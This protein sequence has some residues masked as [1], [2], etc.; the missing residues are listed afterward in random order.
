MLL[1]TIQTRVFALATAAALA[2]AP[3]ASGQTFLID[4]GPS[5]NPTASP[6][7]NGNQWNSFAPG[8][9]FRL[10]DTNGATSAGAT[11]VGIGFGA[12]TPV[13]QGPAMGEGL[14]NPNPA[15]LGDLAIQTAT[16][17]FVF[18]SDDGVGQPEN[19]RFEFSNLDQSLVYTIRVFASRVAGDTRETEY[20]ATGGNGSQ[21]A[22]LLT[23]NNAQDVAVIGGITPTAAGVIAIDAVAVQGGFCYMNVV[24]LSVGQALDIAV[25]PVGTITDAGGMLSFDAVVTP[26]TGVTMQWERDGVPLANDARIS[27]ANSATLTIDPAGLVDVGMYRLVADG[28]GATLASEEVVGVVRGSPLGLPDFNS[29][30]TVD[31]LDVLAFLAAFDAVG[32]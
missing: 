2:T 14:A 13:G 29:D 5:S 25:Q 18:R 20:T 32:G 8:Q 4:M 16:E 23:S 26:S 31:F 22:Q 17:D 19:L 12:T 27:G 6:D 9:F 3:Q 7:A 30:G 15:L 21:S 10:R 1:K 11:A 24:E 28:G